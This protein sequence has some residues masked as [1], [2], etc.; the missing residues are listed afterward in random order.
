MRCN[1]VKLLLLY[2][3]GLEIDSSLRHIYK[4]TWCEIDPSQCVCIPYQLQ[5][6]KSLDQLVLH[7]YRLNIIYIF[8]ANEVIKASDSSCVSLL[9]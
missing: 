5:S 4:K 6:V 3:T 8:L 1:C 9:S 7:V 2:N